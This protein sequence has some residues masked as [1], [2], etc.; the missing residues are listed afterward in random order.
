M[1]SKS[2]VIIL[3]DGDGKNTTC[4]NKNFADDKVMSLLNRRSNN[5]KRN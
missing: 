5:L 1:C 4:K 2:K 3:Y